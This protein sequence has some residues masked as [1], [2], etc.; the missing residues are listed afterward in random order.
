MKRTDKNSSSSNNDFI[1]RMVDEIYENSS[2]GKKPALS[3]LMESLLNE[4]MVR[5]RDKF[6]QINSSE[7]SNGF[8]PR[9]LNLTLGELNLKVPRVRSGK[10]SFR[11]A[12]LPP[13]WRRID[14]DY[15]ELLI[16]MLSKGYS[17][18]QIER[19]CKKLQLPFSPDRLQ[20]ALELIQDKLDF[21]KTQ[22]LPSDWL[23]I[24][25]DAYHASLKDEDRKVHKT[26][27]FVAVG[28]DLD[29]TK[30]ILGFWVCRGSENKAFWTE[31]FQDLIQRGVHKILLMVSDNFRG[32]PEVV[33]KLFPFADH[34]LCLIHM[35]RNLHRQLSKSTVQEAIRLW[36]AIQN[37]RDYSEG[38]AYFEQLVQLIDNEKKEMTKEYRALKTNYLAFLNYPQQIRKYLYTTNAVES[39]NS[40]I[41][42]MR[43]DLGGY[44]PS[45]RS[46]EVN[47]FI[48][49][50]N[51]QH[52]WWRKP[53]PAIR[54]RAY[55]IR[56]IFAL[57]YELDL[58][59]KP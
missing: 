2:Q 17:Q 45:L 12:I 14:K 53:V 47:L 6:L 57:R 8:Y 35:A 13:R 50:I 41:E 42:K 21:Y 25:I 59:K 16:A 20:E 51:L 58:D 30:H 22:P 28:I 46:L 29:G 11:P 54:S 31:V 36:R 43:I 5:E 10:G 48:P 18:S 34:Q 55:E 37:A 32:L 7:Q 19:A 49:F 4:I 3:Y 24:F 44:F 33:K 39:I 26:V 27:I 56:Q 40:G 23:A 15:E 38:E 9:N 52:R 1:Q